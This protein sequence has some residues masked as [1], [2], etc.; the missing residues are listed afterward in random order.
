MSDLGAIDVGSLSK[1]ASALNSNQKANAQQNAEAGIEIA[2]MS[3]MS[4][5]RIR[6][7]RDEV[8]LQNFVRQKAKDLHKETFDRLDMIPTNDF[9]GQASEIGKIRSETAA[10]MQTGKRDQDAQSYLNATKAVMNLREG[11]KTVMDRPT[12]QVRAFNKDGTA[13]LNDHDEFG[14]P[15]PEVTKYSRPMSYSKI[16]ASASQDI[17]IARTAML[18]TPES[19]KQ[20]RA[21]EMGGVGQNGKPNYVWMPGQDP[22]FGNVPRLM[23]ADESKL[24]HDREKH[25][26]DIQAAQRVSRD[27]AMDTYYNNSDSVEAINRNVRRIMNETGAHEGAARMIYDD[28]QRETIRQEKHTRI[29]NEVERIRRNWPEQ[30]ANDPGTVESLF[31]ANFGAGSEQSDMLAVYEEAAA[32]LRTDNQE[33]LFKN[34]EEQTR[35]LGIF[36]GHSKGLDTELTPEIVVS[37]RQSVRTIFD[38]DQQIQ[39][40]DH[41]IKSLP[42][43]QQLAAT[44]HNKRLKVIRTAT[45]YIDPHREQAIFIRKNPVLDA[46]LREETSLPMVLGAPTFGANATTLFGNTRELQDESNP[47]ITKGPRQL[48]RD[49]EKAVGHFNKLVEKGEL[50]N[51]RF[52]KV[53]PKERWEG[54]LLRAGGFVA[55]ATAGTEWEDETYFLFNPLLNG[56]GVESI[57]KDRAGT[58]EKSKELMERLIVL[59]QENRV[60][61]GKG[62]TTKLERMNAFRQ[63]NETGAQTQ[64][65]GQLVRTASELPIDDPVRTQLFGQAGVHMP[66]Q[67]PTVQTFPQIPEGLGAHQVRQEFETPEAYHAAWARGEVTSS[68]IRVAGHNYD[69]PLR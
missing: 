45:S 62:Y 59:Q 26:E 21:T 14:R 56:L 57:G 54:A 25:L 10:K 64:F 47:G 20:A 52:G 42:G 60:M 37:P 49:F 63:R 27:I 68:K 41:A 58:I 13:I 22:E 7:V 5:S 44:L 69:I 11:L 38:L 35:I 6:Q 48:F 67:A 23:D 12:I 24:W 66:V 2:K 34:E 43:D 1:F 18:N 39:M 55:D 33:A 53:G 61:R 36:S 4:P 30:W 8:Q 65:R 46:A 31:N 51:N 40:N 9:W 29:F 19:Q 28:Q 16:L 32:I 50:Q 17:N 3:Q 15:N